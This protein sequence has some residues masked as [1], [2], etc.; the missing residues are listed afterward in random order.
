MVA[1]KVGV[2]FRTEVVPLC[3]FGV[4]G[5]ACALTAAEPVIPSFAAEGNVEYRVNLPQGGDPYEQQS[6]QFQFYYTNNWWQADVIYNNAAPGRPT[7]Q[8]C[9]KVPGGTRKY[10]L[11]EG[12]SPALTT[13]ADVCPTLFPPPGLKLLFATWISLCPRPELP[14]TNAASGPRFLDLPACRLSLINHPENRG[15][16][17]VRHAHSFLEH[18]AISN[19]GWELKIG[20]SN[21]DEIW[22]YPAP[23]DNGFT[24]FE[25][26]TLETTNVNG[27]VFPL[28]TLLKEFR[29]RPGGSSRED[30][31]AWVTT[32]LSVSRI[33]VSQDAVV[34]RPP[35]PQRLLALDSRPAKLP[36]GRTA[37]YIVSNDQWR[38]VSDPQLASLAQIARQPEPGPRRHPAMPRLAVWGLL[39]AVA[40]TPLILF[41]RQRQKHNPKGLKL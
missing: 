13:P 32:E 4:G 24:E 33:V 36:K 9:M 10:T 41:S 22:R 20:G 28:R 35:A 5:L 23:Y 37:D 17:A 19:N 31:Y 26:R 38:A 29:P 14:L 21:D 7:V 18:L 12:T 6:A 3:A 15:V 25:Y 16:Y 30:V 39:V 27:I 1:L 8:S 34:A 2:I 40:L 11:F